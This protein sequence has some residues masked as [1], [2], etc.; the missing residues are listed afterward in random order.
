VNS[1]KRTLTTLAAATTA[2]LGVTVVSTSPAAAAPLDG[3][4]DYLATRAG[5]V[6]VAVYDNTT[7]K[8]SVYTDADTTQYTASIMKVDI[9]A[10]WLRS[11]QDDKTEIPSGV[12]YSLQYLMTQMIQVSDNSAATALFHFGGGCRAFTKF[13]KKIPMPNTDVGCESPTYYGWG[14]TE[15]TAAD[16][17]RLMRA[18]AY[19]TPEKNPKGKKGKPVLGKAARTYGLG[20]MENIQ[21]DQ[22]WGITCGPWGTTCDP[23]NYAPRDPDITVAHKNGWKTL[24][25]CSQPIAQCPWQVNSIG[26]V[27]GAGRDYVIAVLTTKD[28]VGAGG[29]EGFTYG[30]TTI[31]GVSRLVW[32][33]LG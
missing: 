2:A 24:P 28:P 15:T 3:V 17:V 19:G 26:W 12:P 18:F 14:N 13:N 16:Q 8:T 25:T 23:P 27:K 10:G 7:G 5:V 21:A 22:S 29:T 33:N 1:F 4:E 30:I 32:D 31:Q 9:L 11:F 6:Q 20:L